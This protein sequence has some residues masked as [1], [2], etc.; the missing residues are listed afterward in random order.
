MIRNVILLGVI[1]AALLSSAA[2]AQD[3]NVSG[4]LAV[5]SGTAVPSKDIEIFSPDTPTIRFNQSGGG[6][7]P[8]TWDIGANEANFFIRDS[9]NGSQLPFRIFPGAVTNTLTLD[10]TG[11]G[12]GIQH[13]TAALHVNG[14]VRFQSLTGCGGGL[15]TDASGYLSCATQY[16]TTDGAGNILLGGALSGNTVSI[17][18]TSGNRTLTGVA[19]GTVSST[20]T[21]AV[22]GSQLHGVASSI[23][24]ALGGS[25]RVLADGTVSQ[26]TYSIGGS[27]RTGVA[28]ALGALDTSVTS[29]QNTVAAIQT[30]T[31]GS[32]PYLAS[33]SSG[34]PAQAVG[35]NTLALGANSIAAHDNSTAIGAGAVTTR[36]NQV[37]I[38]SRTSTYTLAG[39]ASD[40]S[41]DNQSGPLQVLTSDANGNVA[42]RTMQ[43]FFPEFGELRDYA[44]E[45]RKEARQGIA[46]AMAMAVAPSPSAV[47]RTSWATNMGVFKDELAFGAAFAHRVDFGV[48]A[49]ITGGYAYG[50][51]N[52]H[53]FRVGLSGEF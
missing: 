33:S 20:S 19:A 42:A 5:G 2:R 13:A 43:D 40:A 12:I 4:N 51:G 34:R 10:S 38:G 9:T 31:A 26:P 36:P 52:T 21:D 8:Y 29:L 24:S 35:T 22:N 49:N 16:L 11:V 28:S 23:A 50:G 39:V 47:G 14:T 18:G 41:R 15:Q 45:T 30:G 37:A 7:S 27:N 48:I 17:A 46:A 1:A 25:A 53:G 44:L 6:F 3:Y 32:N